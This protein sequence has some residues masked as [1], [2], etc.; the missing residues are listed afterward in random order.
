MRSLL[1]RAP[2]RAALRRYAST[3]PNP[4]LQKKAADTL[5]KAEKG[6]EQAFEAGKKYAGPAQEQAAQLWNKAKQYAGPA[7]ETATKVWEAGVRAA[8]PVGQKVNTYKGPILYNLAVAREIAKHVYR[9]EKMSPPSWSTIKST[10]A[11][12]FSQAINPSFWR[13]SIRSGEIWKL[14]VISLE[15][16]GIYKIGEIIGRRHLVG[17]N[18]PASHH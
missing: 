11:S 5:A 1:S 13:E 8:G 18:V 14:G 6:V 17:Y 2:L 3:S 16:Y 4:E 7:G 9:T 10:Y 15:A 12:L